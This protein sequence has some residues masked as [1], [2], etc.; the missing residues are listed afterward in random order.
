GIY[1]MEGG[2]GR[3]VQAVRGGV[4]GYWAVSTR[5][6]VF[7]GRLNTPRPALFVMRR[8]MRRAAPVAELPAAPLL[9]Q[10]GLSLSADGSLI[11]VSLKDSG[12]A[13]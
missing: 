1:R 11:L 8:R 7:L 2:G 6:M 13:R 5:G 9:R 4:E 12:G 3:G 10:P